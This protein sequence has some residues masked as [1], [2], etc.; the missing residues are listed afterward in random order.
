MKPP[1]YPMILGIDPSR[2]SMGL[3]FPDQTTRCLKPPNKFKL[4]VLCLAWFRDQ[5]YPLM[6]EGKPQLVV[7]EDYVVGQKANPAGTLSTGELGG[8]I[9]LMLHDLGIPVALVN[10]ATLRSFLAVEQGD[11]KTSGISRLAAKTGRF[12]RTNDEAE[13]WGLAAMGYEHF[14][15]GWLPLVKKQTAAVGRVEWPALRPR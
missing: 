8:V 5:L 4:G 15:H 10:P 1:E 11:D 12:W 6:I 9:R 13:A 14:G 2:S 3:A 7:L